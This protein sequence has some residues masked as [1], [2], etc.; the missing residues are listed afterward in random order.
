[1][2]FGKYKYELQKKA[3][4]AKKKQK[5]VETKEIRL[6]PNI[7]KGDYDVKLRSIHKFLA[8]GDKVRIALKFKGR[9]MAH[10]NVG[11]DLFNRLK[12]DVA[13]HGKIE[14]EPKLE[15]NNLLMIVVPKA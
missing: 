7:G 8:E 1:M 5:V 3:N 9:E 2:D 14:L 10:I 4:E 12:N 6:R 11:M 13:D 15:G